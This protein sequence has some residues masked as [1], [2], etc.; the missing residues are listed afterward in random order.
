[1]FSSFRKF[2]STR[3]LKFLFLKRSFGNRP[4]TLLDIG[5]GN[6]S[7]S[8]TKWL[9]PNCH[10]Y[11]VDLTRDYNND[12][13]DIA[14]MDGFFEMDLTKLEFDEIPGSFFDAIRMT[15]VIEHLYNGD[16]VLKNLV[17]KLKPGGEIYIEYPG[18]K[19]TTL[20]SMQGTLNFYDDDTHVRVY[21]VKE[22]EEILVSKGFV[23]KKSGTKRNIY[24]IAAIPFKV[25]ERWMR[26]KRLTG[27]IFWDLLGFAEFVWAKKN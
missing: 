21:S 17:D 22:I 15:H 23:I 27:N 25:M 12:E 2:A 9:F 8:K 24:N 4:F 18:L 7:A 11:G 1:M 5:S 14:A 13:N 3:S 20:P 6:H 19:S 26:G 16:L 10:Y